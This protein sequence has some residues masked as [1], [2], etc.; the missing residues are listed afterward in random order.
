MMNIKC[1]IS[2]SGQRILL[3]MHVGTICSCDYTVCFQNRPLYI[4]LL[5]FFLFFFYENGTYVA[6]ISSC[7]TSVW[8]QKYLFSKVTLHSLKGQVVPLC[9]QNLF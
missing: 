7:E 4:P 1:P 3:Y 6:C 9:L 2:Y 5:S 8:D